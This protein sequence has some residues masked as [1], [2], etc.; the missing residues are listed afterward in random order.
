M[1]M[2]MPGAKV[3]FFTRMGIKSGLL[4]M[5]VLLSSIRRLNLVGT[6]SDPFHS[7]QAKS[8]SLSRFISVDIQNLS[9]YQGGRIQIFNFF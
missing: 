7:P 3:P 1:T 6:V 5:G 4:I 8:S 9:V 2:V